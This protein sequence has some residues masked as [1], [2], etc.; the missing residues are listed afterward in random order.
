MIKEVRQKRIVICWNQIS[1]IDTVIFIVT[2]VT[3]VLLWNSNRVNFIEWI[4]Q[5]NFEAHITF[6][7]QDWNNE[8]MEGL[9]V[10]M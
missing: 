1:R 7:F 3:V 9:L 6:S 5:P 10:L 4:A 8:I 2:V